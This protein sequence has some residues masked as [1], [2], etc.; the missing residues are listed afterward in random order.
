MTAYNTLQAAQKRN[1]RR[2]TATAQGVLRSCVKTPTL[3]ARRPVISDLQRSIGNNSVVL[4][5]LLTL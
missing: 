2:M 5:T 1:S 4:R 3:P